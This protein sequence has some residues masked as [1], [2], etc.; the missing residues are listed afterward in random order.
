[1][2]YAL[3]GARVHPMTAPPIEDGVVLVDDG[4]ISKVGRGLKVPRGYE[5]LDCTGGNLFPGFVEAHCHLGVNREGVGGQG[6]Q[7]NEMTSPTT[8]T[9][10][11]MDAIDVHDMHFA[12]A[13]FEGGVTAACVSPGSANVVGGTTDVISVAP[14]RT[15]AELMIRERTSLK[16]A[17]GENPFRVYGG[18]NKAPATRMGV[19][20]VLRDQ[21]QAT[22]NYMARRKDARKDKKH[23]DLDPRHE[24]LADLL[25]GRLVA[26]CHAHE[27]FDI[28]TALR[29]AAEFRYRMVLVHGTGA[30]SLLPELKAA[31]MDVILGPQG[32]FNAKVEN[33]DRDLSAARD[34]EA[35]GIRFAISTDHPV[36]PLR[37]LRI[38]AAKMVNR[39]LDPTA[40][41][42]AL[43][44]RPARILGLEDELGCIARGRRADLVLWEGSPLDVA[45][46]RVRLVMVGGQVRTAPRIS[47]GDYRETLAAPMA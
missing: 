33:R 3:T 24:V 28:E 8:P 43:T 26:H 2:R 17:F 15:V 45:F 11:A 5:R 14:S 46:G 4:R 21:L 16:M 23:V 47:A 7:A 39:G 31:R 38:E 29:V 12:K 13:L 30:P 40:A 18:Q 32:G 9:M 44:I 35:A 1:M 20:A 6:A 36:L 10:R 42:E 37:D 25:E 41:L 27:S 34:L 22:R 19:A